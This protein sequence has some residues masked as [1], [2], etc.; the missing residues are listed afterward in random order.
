MGRKTEEVLEMIPVFDEHGNP[1]SNFKN[2]NQSFMV[3]KNGQVICGEYTTKPFNAM[4][5][6]FG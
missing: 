6:T 4:K 5:E 1:V 3:L 2:K